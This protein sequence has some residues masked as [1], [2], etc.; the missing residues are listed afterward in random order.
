MYV[1]IDIHIKDPACPLHSTNQPFA[2]RPPTTRSYQIRGGPAGGLLLLHLYTTD[3]GRFVLYTPSHR[4]TRRTTDPRVLHIRRV[5]KAN[6]GRL[7]DIVLC[8]IALFHGNYTY[9]Y[10]HR[11]YII[12]NIIYY[13]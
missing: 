11:Y 3:E 1:Y 9:A 8:F 5:R 7:C 2:A 6:F 12:N 4:S 13:L 10:N